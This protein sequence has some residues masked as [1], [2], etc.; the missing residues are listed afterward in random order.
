MP[1]DA[2]P[3]SLSIPALGRLQPINLREVWGDEAV[4]FTP[5]L[6]LPENLGVLGEALGMQL[7]PE[8]T[9]AAVGGFS[10]DIL[11]RNAVDNS[12]V[13]VENQLEQTDHTH[14]GQIL[15]YLAG[16]DARTV[17]WIAR[18]IR[19]EHR[20]ACE[21]LNTNTG[22]AFRFFAVEVELWRI[23]ESAP[24]PR[25]NIV[26]KPNDWVKAERAQ[27]A[28]SSAETLQLLEF[29]TALKGWMQAHQ[30]DAQI[31]RPARGT[32]VWVPVQDTPFVLSVFCA[33]GRVGLFVRPAASKTDIAG[34]ES[35]RLLEKLRSAIV[36]SPG[37]ET[38]GEDALEIH[39]RKSCDPDDKTQWPS[40]FDWLTT[41][42][43]SYSKAVKD[44]L[45]TQQTMSPP[46]S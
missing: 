33:K 11:A 37:L 23:G 16:L 7:T 20:A 2:A 8:R 24:A 29:W 3:T 9:E 15:T 39:V 4:Q 19:D 12:V 43:V 36:A 40:I 26:V 45:N 42:I 38:T 27:Q 44:A 41:Q 31:D 10:A 13:V 46:V 17:V 25:F 32:N 34:Q 14:L 22:E 21:W 1:N 18:R 35:L 6:A 30:S 5:W 28:Q